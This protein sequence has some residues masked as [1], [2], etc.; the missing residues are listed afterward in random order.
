MDKETLSNYGWVVIVVVILCILI[1]LA[2]PFGN[3]I[4]E[5]TTNATHALKQRQDTAFEQ[6]GIKTQEKLQEE[7]IAVE[8]MKPM[9]AMYTPTLT[10]EKPTASTE[11]YLYAEKL[12]KSANPSDFFNLKPGMTLEVKEKNSEWAYL[13]TGDVLTLYKDG[14]KVNDYILVVLGDIN[15]DGG[16]DAFDL[17]ICDSMIYKESPVRDGAGYM[18]ADLNRDGSVDQSEYNA[19]RSQVS[20]GNY[21][22]LF[23]VAFPTK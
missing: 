19:I 4:S 8:A 18:A 17:S 5:S 20:S 11:F 7:K 13:S 15:R 3:Y 6:I 1:A 16:I 2:S 9:S 10:P 21:Q 22:A 14:K 23:D 12:G